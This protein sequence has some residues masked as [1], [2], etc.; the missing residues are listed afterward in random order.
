M[1]GFGTGEARIQP[2]AE[3]GPVEKSETFGSE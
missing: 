3:S 1:G 2:E